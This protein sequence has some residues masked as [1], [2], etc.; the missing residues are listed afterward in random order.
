MQCNGWITFFSLLLLLWR[1]QIWDTGAD[2][3]WV[4][5]KRRHEWHR[6]TGQAPSLNIHLGMHN[7]WITE[8]QLTDRVG[9]VHFPLSSP[10]S[11]VFTVMS[12][13]VFYFNTVTR[14]QTQSSRLLYCSDLL[15]IGTR[16]SVGCVKS[17]WELWF[18][19]AHTSAS[20][21]I[22]LS[23]W[24]DVQ[25]CIKSYRVLVQLIWCTILCWFKELGLYYL[26]Y[27]HRL[28]LSAGVIYYAHRSSLWCQPGH[29]LWQ[30]LVRL[31][32]P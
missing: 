17:V 1:S 31:P 5:E 22:T 15:G 21:L 29:Y 8:K 27:I 32:L 14:P 28:A 13:Q 20:C 3:F 2:L 4:S 11:V 10:T 30:C 25:T 24:R 26:S 6:V 7:L 9:L 23:V 19:A 16:V 18:C 12:A